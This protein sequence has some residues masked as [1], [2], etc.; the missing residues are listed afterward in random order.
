MSLSL[1]KTVSCPKC[2]SELIRAIDEQ[3]GQCENCGQFIRRGPYPYGDAL[4]W[5]LK[6]ACLLFGF[7]PC[8]FQLLFG[9]EL[10][11]FLVV[12]IVCTTA[13]GYGTFRRRP[14]VA[15]LVA[16]SLFFLN[17]AVGILIGCSQTHR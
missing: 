16:L 12:N 5:P 1:K 15:T 3:Y 6:A 2:R 4:F 8:F 13:A 7:A 14:I 17:F 10:W 9:L 11:L